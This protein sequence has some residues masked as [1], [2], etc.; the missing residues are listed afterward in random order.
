M[1]KRKPNSHE[2]A[3][4][5]RKLGNVIC[6]EIEV[7]LGYVVIGSDRDDEIYWGK[8]LNGDKEMLKE[9]VVI[10]AIHD[11][12][13]IDSGEVGHCFDIDLEDIL[14]FA[15]KHCNGIYTRVMREE[16]DQAVVRK[17]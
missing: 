2:C 11:G 12:F 13:D 10:T 7:S 1:N 5:G 17:S 4:Y 6:D 3:Y 8:C 16:E 15:A 9:R 14:R